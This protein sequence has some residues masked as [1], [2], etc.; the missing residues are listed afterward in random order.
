[1]PKFS[2]PAGCRDAMT[3]LHNAHTERYN[4][5]KS[6]LQQMHAN[7][8]DDHK[9]INAFL[10]THHVLQGAV[11]HAL[12]RG[13]LP[14]PVRDHLMGARTHANDVHSSLI[15]KLETV[16]TVNPETGLERRTQELVTRRGAGIGR[17]IG[18]E[19]VPVGRS[20]AG[21]RVNPTEF[22]RTEVIPSI[23]RRWTKG[24][25]YR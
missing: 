8:L 21:Q 2:V 16:K 18:P 19:G 9:L 13:D 22:L 20:Q 7:S 12:Q 1:M 23:Q 24:R 17:K 10:D 11:D 5:V 15:G 4:R 14:D 6:R 25:R 3:T